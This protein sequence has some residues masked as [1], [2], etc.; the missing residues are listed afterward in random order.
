M[1]EACKKLSDF[2][3]QC[4][5]LYRSWSLNVALNYLKEAT[6]PYTCEKCKNVEILSIKIF[7]II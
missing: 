3:K 7:Q 6:S 5:C 2:C 4:K 1:Y